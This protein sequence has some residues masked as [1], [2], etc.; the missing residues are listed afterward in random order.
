MKNQ[1]LVLF[2]CAFLCACNQPKSETEAPPVVEVKS[3]PLEVG[4]S[5]YAEMSRQGL[6]SLMAGDLD[7]F[8]ANLSDNSKFTW[9]YADSLMGKQAIADYWKE[10]RN[11]VIDTLSISNEVWI[12]L[13]A[14]E[15]VAPGIPTG[16]WVM[17]W[18]KATAK[19]KATGKSM[20]QWIH[21]I[22]HF[23]ASD[24]IDF[25]SQYLDRVPIQAALKK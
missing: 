18:Y 13:K 22:Q 1:T 12:T 9:N 23:D 14:N 16:T 4:D 19:Y 3:Q 10:R 21:Q 15:P 6:R 7:G 17:G 24:K 11:N 20:T 5:K 8:T 25:T 2:A